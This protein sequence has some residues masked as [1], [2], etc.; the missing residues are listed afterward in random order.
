MTIKT[1]TI[2]D[3]PT[4]KQTKTSY[5]RKSL[6]EFVGSDAE[7]AEITDWE[8]YYVSRFSLVSCIN[9]LI[10]RYPDVYGDAYAIMR[11]GRVFLVKMRKWNEANNK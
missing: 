5:A 10:T 11:N 6:D 2:E 9:G 1:I 7:A 3:I 4:T 8:D